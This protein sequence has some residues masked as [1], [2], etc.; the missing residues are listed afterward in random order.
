ME[1]NIIIENVEFSQEKK[2]KNIQENVFNNEYEGGD[3]DAN[4]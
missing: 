2:K 1:D 3:V 4:N